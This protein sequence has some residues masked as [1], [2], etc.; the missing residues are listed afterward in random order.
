[1]LAEVELGE[2]DDSGRR[3][4]LIS[5]RTMTIACDAVLLA[6]GQTEDYGLLPM[7]GELPWG[8]ERQVT[9]AGRG[10]LLVFGAG[11]ITTGEGTVPHA[12]GSGRRAAGL[13]LGMFARYVRERA[14]HAHGDCALR[15]DLCGTNLSEMCAE[16]CGTVCSGITRHRQR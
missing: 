6:L 8:G 12:I 13:L 4:S 9:Y 2:P 11:D 15:S 1:M 3:R 5:N 7:D 16:V 14:N 10:E